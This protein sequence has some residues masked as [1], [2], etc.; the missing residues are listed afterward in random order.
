MLAHYGVAIG[1]GLVILAG[2]TAIALAAKAAKGI[3]QFRAEDHQLFERK[4]GL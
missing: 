1:F 2:A 3:T 4:K